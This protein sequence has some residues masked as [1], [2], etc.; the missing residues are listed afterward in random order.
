MRLLGFGRKK[1]RDADTS[2]GAQNLPIQEQNN[3]QQ[4]PL[5]TSPTGGNT[6]SD[7]APPVTV[8]PGPTPDIR[9]PSSS[10]SGDQL[11][12]SIY[13]EGRTASTGSDTIQDIKC[14]ILANWLHTKQ[15]EKVWTTSS[16]G[17]GV[18]VKKSKGNYACAPYESIGDGSNMYQSITTLNVRVSLRTLRLLHELLKLTT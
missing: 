11:T 7:A 18:F 14:E 12:N 15:E 8:N 13:S 1:K 16:A 5:M 2:R 4:T 6:A 17:E 9:P 3:G 10:Y